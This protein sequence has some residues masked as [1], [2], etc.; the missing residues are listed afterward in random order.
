[1]SSDVQTPDLFDRGWYLSYMYYHATGEGVTLCIAIG[2]SRSYA[3][4]VLKER[5]HKYFYPAIETHPMDKEMR[6]GP[7][8]IL[9]MIPEEVKEKFRRFPLGAGHYFSELYYNLA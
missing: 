4:S 7:S 2:G 5:L 3:E 8:V 1:M 9:Q 6:G